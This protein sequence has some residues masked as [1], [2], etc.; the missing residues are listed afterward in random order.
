MYNIFTSIQRF[1]YLPLDSYLLGIY[2]VDNLSN[3]IYVRS[4]NDVQTKY[5]VMPYKDEYVAMPL[6]TVFGSLKKR[7]KVT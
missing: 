6:Q 7:N 3:R 1:F 5:I 4:F 2:R